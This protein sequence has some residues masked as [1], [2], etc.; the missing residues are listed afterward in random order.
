MYNMQPTDDLWIPSNP[1]SESDTVPAVSKALRLLDCFEIGDTYLSLAQ[2]SRRSGLNKST[3]L[4]LARLLAQ[5]HYLVK[6]PVDGAWRLGPAAGWLGARYQASH[7]VDQTIGAI[8]LELSQK[9]QESTSFFVREGDVRN[10]L[11]RVEG[12]KAIRHHIRVGEPLPLDKGSPG[13]V[14]LAFTGQPGPL[15]EAIRQRGY[16]ISIGERDK[17]IASISAPVFGV[18]WQLLGA[19][20]V[21]GP[22]NRLDEPTLEQ[23]ARPLTA[24]AS[25]LSYELGQRKSGQTP[26]LSLWH[27]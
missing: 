27:P 26:T 12:P 2:I 21:S 4:R 14:L 20:S 18:N 25:R 24:T 16:C 17:E 9:T 5:H 13:K 6:R 3:L 1:S 23:F 22:A 15:Y 11:V 10:C 8:L 7:D 19:I